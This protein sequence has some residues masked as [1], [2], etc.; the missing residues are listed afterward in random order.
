MESGTGSGSMTT[1]FARCVGPTGVAHVLVLCV[2]VRVCVC[3]CVCVRLCLR[4]CMCLYTCT[5]THAGHVYT[6]DFHEVR[7]QQAAKEFLTHGMSKTVTCKQ[8]DAC[9]DGFKV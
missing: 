7:A 9:E 6:F 3:V 1:A 4:V 5:C 8:A 2:F